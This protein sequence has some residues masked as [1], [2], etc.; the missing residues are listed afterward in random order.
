MTQAIAPSPFVGEGAS[1]CD[2]PPGEERWL[3]GRLTWMRSSL[4]ATGTWAHVGGPCTG[5]ND[6]RNVRAR[7][8]GATAMVVIICIAGAVLGLVIALISARL[9]LPIVLRSQEARFGDDRIDR[10]P[11]PA[12]LRDAQRLRSLTIA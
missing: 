7:G 12:A 9:V 11:L 1:M 3:S 2:V 8:L 6:R 5:W 10:L 4:C